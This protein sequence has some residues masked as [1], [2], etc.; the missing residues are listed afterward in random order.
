[1]GGEIVSHIVDRREGPL[2]PVIHFSRWLG[3]RAIEH[4]FLVLSTIFPLIVRTIPELLAGPWPLGFDTVWIYAP[5]VRDVETTGFVPALQEILNEQAAPFVYVLL[6]LVAISTNAAP[7]AVTKSAAPLLYGFLGFSLYAFGRR[8]LGWSKE[9]SLLLVGVSALYFVPLRFSWD[10]Y[11]NTLGL[12]FFF[13]VLSDLGRIHGGRGRLVLVLG[14]ALCILSSELTAALLAGTALL[15]TLWTRFVGRRWDVPTGCIAA[16]GLIALLFYGHVIAHPVP[17]ASPL[18][19]YPSQTG[20]LYNYVSSNEDVYVYP[21]VFDVYASM[22]ALT[23]FLF[24]PI[25]PLAVLGRFRQGRLGATSVVLGLA[26]ASVLVSPYAAI[27]AWHRWLYVLV[28]PALVF[29]TAG[30]VK[31]NRTARVG[32][33]AALV[34]LGATFVAM[35][36]GRAFPYY[37][38][39]ETVR[40]VPTNLMRNTVGLQDSTDVVAVAG[41]VTD[42]HFPRAVL[43]ADIWFSGWARLYVDGMAVYE[44]VDR[45]QVD[46]GNFSGY[47]HV[48]LMYWAMDQGGYRASEVPS[49]A[50]PIFSVG[51]IGAYEIVPNGSYG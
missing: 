15:L 40:F 4:R 31:L 25:L 45:S 20:L 51:R 9:R 32:V 42:Q 16:L 13:L 17:I 48:L 26:F 6:G 41:W 49:G 36:D 29:A 39:P 27:P 33:L 10:M 37:T 11:K 23:L 34:I 43:V 21:T 22:V 3:Q 8:G 1:V 38:F 47:D 28:F 18:A 7:F 24:A 46:Q 12:S 30:I 2:A 19:P 35:P 44:F 14:A 50:S 5:F